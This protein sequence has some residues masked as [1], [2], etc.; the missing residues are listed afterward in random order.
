MVRTGSRR[1]LPRLAPPVWL[2]VAVGCSTA[3][4][5]AVDGGVDADLADA[6]TAC[7]FDG[8]CDDGVACT[9]GACVDSS[10]TYTP[11]DGA[12][13]DDDNECTVATCDPTLGCAQRPVQ[14]A[15][16][17]A[18]GVC[19]DGACVACTS[20]EHC[21]EGSACAVATCQ[22]NLCVYTPHDERCPDDGDPC[23][24][25][26]CHATLGCQATSL[27]GRL[28]WDNGPLVSSPG[29]GPGGTD[30]SV[31]QVSLGLDSFGF[32]VG[33]SARM[34]DDF[35]VDDPQGWRINKVVLYGYQTDSTTTST[36]DH[37]NYRIWDGPPDEPDSNIVFGNTST[38]RL[39]ATGFTGVYRNSENNPDNTQRPIM[40]LEASAAVTLPPGTYW[41][42]WQLGG[43]LTSGP[44]QPPITITG[45]VNTG[46]ALRLG[47][48]EWR[49]LV[50]GGIGTPQG[51]PFQLHL[52]CPG[53]P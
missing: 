10:C 19:A 36:F 14:G 9:V 27:P 45:E 51:A 43:T 6:A 13:A 12:C 3:E 2:A 4:P 17:C 20:V 37:V 41:L 16:P 18:T 53:P 5:P 47:S 46:D 15:A 1:R 40:Y 31:L 32:A 34:A 44:W 30:R 38:N 24:A 11:D 39:T 7:V 21:T 49:P 26:A 33:G 23:T 52:A 29:T 25:A 35:T 8:D 48:G 42:D 50:D 28:L 22:D